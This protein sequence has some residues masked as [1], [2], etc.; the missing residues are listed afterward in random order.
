MARISFAEKEK[1]QNENLRRQ[2]RQKNR[3][4]ADAFQKERN[5]EHAKQ[6][7]VKNR[8]H[9]VQTFD[10]ILGGTYE[11]RKAD[12]EQPPQRGEPFCVAHIPRLVVRRERT[13]MSP[14]I[15][16]AGRAECI[17]FAG[18]GRKRGRK[19]HRDQQADDSMWQLRQD[20]GDE[21]VIR[22][23]DLRVGIHGFQGVAR[24]LAQTLRRFLSTGHCVPRGGFF[25][26]IAR[27]AGGNPRA[28]FRLLVGV[29]HGVFFIDGLEP[30]ALR[31]FDMTPPFGLIEEH[32]RVRLKLIE[33][34]QQRAQHDD[35]E[36]HRNLENGVEH[37]TEPAFAQRRAADVTLHLRLVGAEIRERQKQPAQHPAPKGV[38]PL[39]I[40]RE[41]HRLQFAHRAGDMQRVGGQFRQQHDKRGDH[42][43][44]DDGHL[45]FLG[46]VHRRASAGDG[47]NDH[48]QPGKNDR[49]IESPAKDGRKD[50][51][52][53]I[54]R[55]TRLHAALQQEERRA[56]QPRLGVE[57]ATE[58][59]VSCVD[60][61][62][63]VNR[64]KHH[65][66][67]D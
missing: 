12:R 45:P 5:D 30:R 22:I 26:D 27:I 67:D 53:R 52:R 28:D 62:P 41:V 42:A 63:A 46:E 44:E 17:Q 21:N 60:A 16:R 58:K 35:E 24:F 32:R 65:A 57:A 23:F 48:E 50:D 9:D 39:Q 31:A 54:N 4:A 29:Q 61:E 1:R 15:Y 18:L 51:G 59:F 11:Q 10:E 37:Q 55:D 43:A 49:E 34:K 33:H 47:V 20:E 13:E 14:Q 38:A 3:R 66:D 64:Q 6:R 40:R 2:R 36:L 8:G 25:R 7:R 19:H 56:K